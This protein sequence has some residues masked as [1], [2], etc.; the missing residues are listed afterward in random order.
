M[1][2]CFMGLICD[3]S[4]NFSMKIVYEWLQEYF[5]E[6]L[7]PA[8][9]LARE[10]TMRAYEVEGIEKVGEFTVLDIDVLPNRAADSLSHAGVAR[11]IGTLLGKPCQVPE[12]QA[13]AASDDSVSTADHVSLQVTSQ[14]VR[15]A[16]KRLAVEVNI[17]ESS[18]AI[19][20]KLEALGHKPKN[21]IVDIT[22]LVMLETGQ[23]V[24]AFDYDKIAGP[25]DGP[26]DIFVREAEAG[27][28]VETLDGDTYELEAGMLVIADEEKPLDIA[29]IKGGAN[30]G[31]DENTTRVLLSVCSF[32]S[33][34]IRSTSQTL[35]LRTDA[36][37][38]FEN[39]PS[40]QL[41]EVAMQRLSQLLTK[42]SGARVA[43]DVL[44]E[45]PQPDEV[46]E[47]SVSAEEINNLLGVEVSAD[48][49][50][51]IFTALSFEWEEAGGVYVVTPPYWRR[52]ITIP[53]DLIEEVG[54][55]YGYDHVEAKMPEA[56]S[57]GAAVDKVFYHAHK[58]RDI[59]TSV[60]FTEVYTYAFQAEGDIELNNP[61]SQEYQYLR[62]S[63]EPGLEAAL[64]ENKKHSAVL[65]TNE[66]AVFEIG[67]V[68]QS[69]SEHQVVALACDSKEK[70]AAGIEALAGV[71]GDDVARAFTTDESVAQA[72]LSVFVESYE[73]DISY[74][75]L[76]DIETDVTYQPFS[77]FPYV[78]RD[79]ALWVPI[80]GKSEK[81]KGER[82]QA[83][84]SVL[85][86]AAGKLLV[87]LRL[88]DEYQ[89][90]GEGRIS[91]AFRLVFQSDDKTLS[92]EEVNERMEAVYTAV[93]EKG[94]EV[95]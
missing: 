12:G 22:N 5:E 27:E 68:F 94:W 43:D 2:A 45:Y 15:R 61:V 60:G 52:D 73:D 89:P 85:K 32:D 65:D 90:E 10:L 95:R 38:R 4:N 91:F 49:I 70:Q 13:S 34:H 28:K 31:I 48:E 16:T 40:A 29:G 86:K 44:D 66:L 58:I 57:S 87:N 9:E 1:C 81:E 72:P 74:D 62:S 14:Y 59:L 88:F 76:A 47:V 71:Y 23:P 46:S 19:K 56:I 30:S 63:L 77:R 25:E 33:G 51:R 8:K 3:S 54:R 17:A 83:V 78:L 24:H 84:K 6:K 55:V 82:K 92:D 11:E 69:D 67:S 21:N 26:K 41:P 35:N 36:S 50:E 80:E 18:S 53:V 42:E 39:D 20:Q 75:D 79:I 93:E 7:P 37:K 64:E